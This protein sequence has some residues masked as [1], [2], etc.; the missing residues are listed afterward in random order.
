MIAALRE[1]YDLGSLSTYF[2]TPCVEQ[3]LCNVGHTVHSRTTTEMTWLYRP[4]L[5]YELLESTTMI[6]N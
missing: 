6:D 3:S 5:S 2:A 1:K 4:D